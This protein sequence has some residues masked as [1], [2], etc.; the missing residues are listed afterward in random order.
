[1]TSILP[2]IE[3]MATWPP[4]NFINPESRAA[5]M[6]ACE[7]PVVTLTVITVAL[8]LISRAFLTVGRIN[9]DDI[10]I[11]LAAGSGIALTVVSLLAIKYGWVSYLRITYI[12]FALSAFFSFYPVSVQRSI[13]RM[14]NS[15]ILID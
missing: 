9:L 14:R 13:Q 4:P 8:R 5:L 12:L 6:L 10:M 3:V 15:K 2:P 1:M 7:V 11:L